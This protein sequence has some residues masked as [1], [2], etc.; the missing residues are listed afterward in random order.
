M[1]AIVGALDVGTKA[2][3]SSTQVKTPTKK[4]TRIHKKEKDGSNNGGFLQGLKKLI[5]GANRVGTE[6]SFGVE[7][8]SGSQRYHLHLL[9]GDEQFK[10][11]TITRIMR[12]IPDINWETAEDIVTTSFE[13]E[14]ALLRVV[15]S[16][17]EAKYIHDVMRGADPPIYVEVFDTKSEMEIVLEK[18]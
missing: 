6:E 14:K 17:K 4:G 8:T 9:K 15:A 5:P 13:S 16:L 2:V 10:R 18:S 3:K 12:H 11:H 7:E 1:Y